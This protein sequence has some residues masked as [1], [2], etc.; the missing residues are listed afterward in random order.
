MLDDTHVLSDDDL[1]VLLEAARWAPSWGNQQPWSYLVGRRGDATFSRIVATLSRGNSGWVPRASAILV[2]CHQVA[3]A[4]GEE[5]GKYAT[6]AHDTGQATAHLTF[7]AVSMGLVVHQFAGFDHDAVAA[8]F[9]VPPHW[10]VL[11]G[12]AVGRLGD[13]ETADVPERDPSARTRRPLD[14]FVFAG[15]WG[16]PAAVVR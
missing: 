2:S 10:R 14:A 4:P 6:S 13:P 7:Q 11:A 1:R 12:L 9:G 16:E 8:E 15:R 3:P 5:P